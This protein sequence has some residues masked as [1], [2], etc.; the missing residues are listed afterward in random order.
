MRQR[1]LLVGA[2]TLGALAFLWPFLL[3]GHVG[4]ASRLV[5]YAWALV[6]PAVLLAAAHVLLARHRDIRRVTLM[7]TLI[8]LA[9][10]ARPLGASVAGLEPMW[11]VILLAGRVLGAEAGFLVGAL[12]MLTSALITG[13]VGPW[14]PYQ[15]MVGAWSGALPSLLPRLR[16][17]LEVAWLMLLGLANGLIVGALLNLWFWPLAVGLSPAIAF[18]PA[19]DGWTN[20]GHWLRN[21]TLTSLG[22]DLPRGILT[23]ALLGLAAGGLLPILRRATRRT[24]FVGTVLDAQPE[25]STMQP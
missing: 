23:A 10:A 17:R 1:A 9:A 18:D 11:T 22:F 2:N 5:P 12:A 24:Q 13:G 6:L 25:P 8:A 19:A 15:M 20:V 7:A 16:G 21:A 4:T 3:G 14:L